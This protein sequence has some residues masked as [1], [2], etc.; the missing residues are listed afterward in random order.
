MGTIAITLANKLEALGY[1]KEYYSFHQRKLDIIKDELSGKVQDLLESILG[2]K[3]FPLGERT[4]VH[5][6]IMDDILDTLTGIDPGE[7]A[8]STIKPLSDRM[9]KMLRDFHKI[10]SKQEA[11]IVSYGQLEKYDW[12]VTNALLRRGLLEF[13]GEGIKLT[14]TGSDF[15]SRIDQE[16]RKESKIS[17]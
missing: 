8:V 16:K 15:A 3:S 11:H 5:N 17:S 6:I 13:E 12:R 7:C 9:V 14:H 4:N 1:G 2:D 10:V